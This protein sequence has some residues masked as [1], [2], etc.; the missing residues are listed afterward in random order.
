MATL[1]QSYKSAVRTHARK[2]EE[3][4]EKILPR[5]CMVISVGLI[6]AG[7]SIHGLMMVDLLPLH[8]LL[9]FAG[10]ALIA[11]GGILALCFSGVL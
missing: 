5:R 3:F 10:F 7:L 2:V 9:G 8:L 6:L 1:T 11:A 4:I